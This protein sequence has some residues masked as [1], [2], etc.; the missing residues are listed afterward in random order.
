MGLPGGLRD[1]HKTQAEKMRPLINDTKN[2]FENDKNFLDHEEPVSA[3]P[4]PN[5]SLMV[6]ELSRSERE[7]IRERTSKNSCLI[8]CSGGSEIYINKQGG[9]HLDGIT[10]DKADRVLPR[11]AEF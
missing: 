1:W 10:G 8:I 9:R 2:E 3:E 11:P 6:I 4:N 7:N 5:Y